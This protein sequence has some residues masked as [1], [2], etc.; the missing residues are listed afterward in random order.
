MLKFR[1]ERGTV[2]VDRS[3]YNLVKIS[4]SF[5]SHVQKRSSPFAKGFFR[6]QT[7][8]CQDDPV[9]QYIF[10]LGM[11]VFTQLLNCRAQLGH[12]GLHPQCKD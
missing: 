11:E 2:G 4:R 9:S 12:V 5:L 8:I 7:G 1:Q 6:G 10:V 3:Q